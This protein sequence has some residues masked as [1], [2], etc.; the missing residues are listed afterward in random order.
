[1]RWEGFRKV[2]R[3]VCRRVD[4]R[5]RALGLDGLPAYRA[6]LEQHEGEWGVLD[7]LCRVTISRF[8]RD[9][10]VFAFL[11]AEVLPTL[12][13]AAAADGRSALEAWSAGCAS[14]E[15][16][17][18]LALVWE[19]GLAARFAAL[20]FRVLATDA[21]DAMLA[22]ARDACYGPS[23]LKDLPDEWR[24]SAFVSR[25]ELFCLR[26]EIKHR[27]TLA[28]H[29]VR[30]GPPAGGP[31]DLVLCRNLVFTYL[32]EGLQHEVAGWILDALRPGGALVV[33]AH[34]APPEIG[35]LTPWSAGLGVYRRSAGGC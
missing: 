10:G 21:D 9:R 12:A 19:L 28:R 30:S 18:T 4:R 29:D 27:V 24:R 1:M 26:D 25:D 35:G 13:R 33:G 23:S 32:D 31:F 15:E 5:R 7:S 14:G 22:R 16:P 17:H 6:Y 3:Q 2:R 34:E 20:D 11:E 8:Y